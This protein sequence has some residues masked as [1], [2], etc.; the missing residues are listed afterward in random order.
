MDENNT[1][2]KKIAPKRRYIL[3]IFLLSVFSFAHIHIS[4]KSLNLNLNDRFIDNNSNPNATIKDQHSLLLNED[5]LPYRPKLIL[6]VGP[7]KTGTTSIQCGLSRFS[8]ELAKMD[9]YYYMGTKCP[10]GSSEYDIQKQTG[11]EPMKPLFEIYAYIPTHRDLPSH[12]AEKLDLHHRQKHNIIISAEKFSILDDSEKTLSHMQSLFPPDKWDIQV[13]VTYRRYYEW[14]PSIWYQKFVGKYR[15]QISDVFLRR[16]K[17]YPSTTI[18]QI[19]LK[20]HPTIYSALTYGK[21]FPVTFFD[22]HQSNDNND[23][24]DLVTNFICHAIPDAHGTCELIH[25]SN[26]THENMRISNDQNAWLLQR[27]AHERGLLGKRI[28]KRITDAITSKFNAMY[29][30]TKPVPQICMKEEDE[31]LLWKTSYAAEKYIMIDNPALFSRMFLGKEIDKIL[32]ETELKKRHLSNFQE[33]KQ[34]GK[35]CNID[36]NKIIE[37]PEWKNLFSS[38]KTRF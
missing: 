1:S 27:E 9:N 13:I 10:E 19:I 26:I 24:D 12:V 34:R 14:I 6:H 22:F 37:D 21:K 2:N 5:S 23:G 38:I 8:G 7:P 36:F 28:N 3:T 33:F 15:G 20:E 35:L 29:N 30:D 17:H 16:M 25:Q 31:Q 4:H 32:N 11:S 18:E